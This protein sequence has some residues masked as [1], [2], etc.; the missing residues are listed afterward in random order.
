[1]RKRAW[2]DN[3]REMTVSA[4]MSR[5]PGTVAKDGPKNRLRGHD[6]HRIVHTFARYDESDPRYTRMVPLIRNGA[7]SYAACLFLPCSHSLLPSA[8]VFMVKS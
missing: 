8:I 5:R 1:M 6:I 2:L 4:P 7:L 3:C